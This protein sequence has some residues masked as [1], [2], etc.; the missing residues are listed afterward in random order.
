MLSY[1]GPTRITH[2]TLNTEG[3]DSWEEAK[4]RSIS[5]GDGVTQSEMK[6]RTTEAD[7]IAR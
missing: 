3:Y 6:L 1:T 5:L 4:I 7:F 2:G